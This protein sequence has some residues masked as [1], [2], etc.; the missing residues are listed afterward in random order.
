MPQNVPRGEGESRVEHRR[1]LE[2]P[3]RGVCERGKGQRE[4]LGMKRVEQKREEGDFR[5]RDKISSTSPQ[6]NQNYLSGSL[7]QQRDRAPVESGKGK[8]CQFSF[9]FVL[10]SSQRP[11]SSFECSLWILPII[12]GP[13]EQRGL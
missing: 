3:A 2:S 5:G 13:R 10:F 7:Q 12:D 6:Q 8:L 1:G 4:S 9:Y 11:S